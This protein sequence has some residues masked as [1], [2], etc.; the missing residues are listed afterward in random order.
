MRP[1]LTH[2]ELYVRDLDAMVALY[3]GCCG[4]RDPGDNCI[5]LPYGQQLGLGAAD[6]T[7]SLVGATAGAGGAKT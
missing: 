2:I 6:G 3:G 7:A 1:K 5:E 4:L